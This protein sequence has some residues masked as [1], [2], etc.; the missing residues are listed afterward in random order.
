MA[1]LLYT[2]HSQC[3]FSKNEII[4]ENRNVMIAIIFALIAVDNLDTKDICFELS[5]ILLV[6]FIFKFDEKL[7]PFFEK[8][9]FIK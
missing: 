4:L 1:L 3:K 5:I 8:N 2:L 7:T 6:N 9:F